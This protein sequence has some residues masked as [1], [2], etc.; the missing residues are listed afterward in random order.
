MGQKWVDMMNDPTI[1]FYETQKEFNNYWRHKTPEKG[2][3]WKQFK[4]WEY[5]MESHVDSDGVFRN[6]NAVNQVYND[7]ITHQA[8]LKT[9]KGPAGN[10]SQIG[11]FNP[12]TG[13]GSGRSNCIAFHPTNSNFILLGTA[14]GGIWKSTNGGASWS[15]NTDG[16][17]NLGIS[18]IVFSPSNPNIVYAATGDRDGGDTY[19]YGLLKSTDGGSHWQPTG[20]AFSA[21]VKR[22]IYKVIIHPQNP[23]ILYIASSFGLR[24][25]ADGG[26]NWIQI[27]AGSFFDVEFKP[28]DANTIYAA[29][30]AIV[31]KSSDAGQSWSTLSIPFTS[32][33]S[34]LII[35]VTPADANY[36]YVLAVKSSDN[37]FEGI[38]RS[39][40]AGVTFTQKATSPNIIGRD[41]NGN[42]NVGQGWYDLALGVSPVNKN[43]ILV[44]GVNI[45]RS[46]NG[47]GSWV[48]SAH[49]TGANGA[50]YVHADI[51]EIKF[52]P[53]NG[54]TV[55]ACTDG[56]VSQS[57]NNG[58]SWS[59][60]NTNLSIAQ[61]YRLGNSASS[62]SK[63][64]TGWQDNGTNLYNNSWGKVLGGDGMECIIDYSNNNTMYGSLYYGNIR[65][66]TNGGNNWTGITKN[67][68]EQ[69][70][71][72]T[73]FIQDPNTPSTLYAGFQNVYKTTNKGNSWQK[74]SNFNSSIS[75]NAIAVSPSNT[76]VIYTS[77]RY[78]LYKTTNGG[79]SWT[80]I[81]GASF[82]SGSISYIAVDPTNSNKLWVTKSGFYNGNKV[83]ASADGGTTWTN[84][85]GSLPNVPANTIVYEKNSADGLY[86][87]MDV[88]I[89]YRDTI[90]GDWIPF[91]KNL[92]NVIVK[93]LE[94]YYPS[95]KIRAAT[96]GRGLWESPLY[97]LANGVEKKNNSNLESILIYPNPSHGIIKI[98]LESGFFQNGTIEVINSSGS[99]IKN[100]VISNTNNYIINF[101]NL[102]NGIYFLRI[103]NNGKYYSRKITLNN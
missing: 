7:Y 3:G 13:S 96:F 61:M 60:K 70:A 93:E 53:H 49:W 82:G 45:W 37:S 39:V 52:S 68:N 64:I 8:Y 87:G 6:Q 78:Y 9:G 75:L 36:V 97:F 21:S 99:V 85:S 38:Y 89:Y 17:E 56:G 24:K 29:T 86:V 103:L 15:T 83:F 42:D 18:D 14:S 67:I 73:P 33:R 44:G 46:I 40:D 72:V 77:N 28:N 11:P 51:H 100:I 81:T 94:I 80:N 43:L 101:N 76:N 5:F 91:M 30:G 62:S 90:L 48:L 88:G 4:R 63:V 34:R 69:G 25:S 65:R 57:T 74:I 54:T 95:N 47:G 66:T 12:P 59:E 1:S 84:I 35:G 19:S 98:K 41:A 79:T 31:I 32:S 10:W 50:P 2:P 23:D 27:R 22:K 16:L 26:S 58:G 102:P 55:W 71:W 20:L 92:P